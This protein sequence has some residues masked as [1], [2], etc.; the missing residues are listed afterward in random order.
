MTFPPA[1]AIHAACILVVAAPIIAIMAGIV[2]L[3]K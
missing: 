2:W 3:I 1:L